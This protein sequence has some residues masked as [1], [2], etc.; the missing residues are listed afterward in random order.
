[1]SDRITIREAT[2]A[3][4]PVLSDLER[5]SPILTSGGWL[6]IDRGDDYFAAARLQEDVTVL[7]AEREG[8][9]LGV[10]CGALH[11]A[12]IADVPRRVLYIHH[13]RIPPEHQRQGLGHRM[14]AELAR[15]YEGR[16]DTQYW[17]ISQANGPSQGFAR[18]APN[19]WP[20]TPLWL[21]CRAEAI[22]G[23]AFGRPCAPADAT[24]IAAMLNA[25]HGREHMF[26]PATPER[27]H[28]RLAR[29]PAQYGW[30]NLWRTER[31]VVGVWLQGERIVTRLRRFDGSVVE[32]RGAA[33]LD[34]GCLPGGEEE[35]VLLLRSWA[36][37][38]ACRGFDSLGVFTWPGAPLE[39]LLRGLAERIEVFDFW[40][41]QLPVPEDAAQRGV[42]VDP[43]YF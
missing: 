2:L 11:D 7:I 4:A 6:T 20:V 17:Y 35:L 23:P 12:V 39:G 26:V 14:A 31:A 30:P 28:R 32:Q 8:E 22:A 24:D 42:Y 9:P 18:R 10:F 21:H 27:L 15:R 25:L 33:V 38:L 5:R 40:T 34:Y 1:M 29:D 43:V 41:P 19:R 13:A 37:E 36:G 3:D 16:F